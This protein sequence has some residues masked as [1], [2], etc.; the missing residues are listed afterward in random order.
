MNQDKPGFFHKILTFVLTIGSDPADSEYVRLI[1][2]IYYVSAV[3]GCVASLASTLWY[4]L[5]GES[6][7]AW[8]FLLSFGLVLGTTV[9]GFLYPR[10]F[11]R[12]TLI[13]LVYFVVAPIL[14]TILLGGIWHTE[15]LI[16]I[17][18]MGP[19]MG[20]VYFL[21]RR[22]AVGL[23]LVYGACVLGLVILEPRFEGSP[24]GLAKMDPINF[25]LGFL[26]VASF[27]FGVMYVFVVQRDKAHRLLAE[28][29]AK[30]ERLLQRI[31]AD[32]R[33]AARIQKD[34]LPKADPRVEG[35]DIGGLNVPCY[36]VGGDYYDFITVDSDRLAIVIADVSGKGIS[37][38][39]LMATLRA[40]LQAEIHPSY[41]PGRM[42]ARLSEFVFKSTGPASFVTFFF[43]ELDHRTGELRYIN[44]G[45]NP[46]FVLD[47]AGITSDLRSS[48]F[49]LGMFLG[50]TYEVG[51]VRL[52]P[53]ELAVLFTDGVT[54]G[55][56][57]QGEEYSG[58]KL[59]NLVRQNRALP[60][61]ALCRTVIDDVH[62]Y[63][64]GTQPCDDMTFFVVKR[65]AAAA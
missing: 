26:V 25:W 35:Y 46:P 18:L 29:K 39:L 34:L 61:E 3:I 2:K 11:R 23:F 15:G 54:E 45:H 8:L 53:G 21:D 33:E 28:E 6:L 38:S 17:G 5:S 59:E 7:M 57:A 36:E 9:D 60:A 1:K 27:I 58:A 20:L 4:F 47:E 32:L 24:A 13:V 14:V 62:G 16:M 44:A 43:G 52:G 30:S 55:R 31:E 51:T 19:L 42:A 41:D 65:S 50:A 56:N 63:A 22:L 37:A 12:I 64:C 49:P 40:A 10:H 48:G